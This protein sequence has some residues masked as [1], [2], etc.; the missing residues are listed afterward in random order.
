MH[1]QCN[2]HAQTYTTHTHAH[3]TASPQRLRMAHCMRI[4]IL[5]IKGTL[6]ALQFHQNSYSSTSL[7]PFCHLRDTPL[8]H[9]TSS[10]PPP[11]LNLSLPVSNITSVQCI[12]MSDSYFSNYYQDCTLCITLKLHLLFNFF[13][14]IFHAPPTPLFS[15]AQKI[16]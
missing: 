15:I 12:C 7:Y 10:E 9:T 8:D 5:A 3:T 2:M 6:H 13:S 11:P 16:C 4:Y 1:Y 14:Q